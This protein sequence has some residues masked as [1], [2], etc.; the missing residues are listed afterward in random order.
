MKKKTASEFVKYNEAFLIKEKGKVVTAGRDFLQINQIGSTLF[1]PYNRIIAIKVDDIDLDN[2]KCLTYIDKSVRRELAFNF[3]EY[4]TKNPGFL[5]L[6]FGLS[7]FRKLQDYLG[8]NVTVKTDEGQWRGVL[9]RTKFNELILQNQNEKYEVN[10][11]SICYLKV[12][13][14]K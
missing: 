14:L 10:L 7:L 3:G 5:N 1:V 12:H 13:D 8:K 9:I 2:K 6:F 4:V 11:N